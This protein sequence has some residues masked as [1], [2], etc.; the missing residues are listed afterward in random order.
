MSEKKKKRF[1]LLGI[2]I[3]VLAGISQVLPGLIAK[4]KPT[5]VVNYGEISVG[6]EIKGYMLRNETVYLSN[7]YW[8][9]EYQKK[10]GNLVKSDT[11]IISFKIDENSKSKEGKEEKSPIASRLGE[12]AVV[13]KDGQAKRKGVVSTFVDGYE[14]YFTAA[15]FKNIK[16]NEVE[17]L[18]LKITDVRDSKFKKHFPIY[19]IADQSR[20][21]VL[22]WIDKEK[23]KKYKEGQRVTL[24]VGEKNIKS[25]VEKIESVG[26][27]TKIMIASNRYYEDFAKMREIKATVQAV[28]LSGIVVPNENIV[29]RDGHQGVYVLSK[30]GEEIFTRV[31]VLGTDGTNSVVKE[32]NFYDDAGNSVKTV[33]AFD[34]IIKKKK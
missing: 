26:K 28:K 21:H 4:V 3:L 27:R 34:E 24:K 30:T 25:E 5:R 22:F 13:V 2:A 14:N 8:S 17:N 10:E 15:N 11:K 29:E 7:D 12:S 18:K 23:A 1:L 19:K 33:K 9:V 20:W 32:D 16:L 6:D 31:K